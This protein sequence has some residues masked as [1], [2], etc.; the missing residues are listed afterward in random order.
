M[1]C[2]EVRLEKTVKERDDSQIFKN[3]P[4]EIIPKMTTAPIDGVFGVNPVTLEMAEDKDCKI[5]VP[6]ILI[7]LKK[8]IIDNNGFMLEGLFRIEGD[9]EK[10]RNLQ[11]DFNYKRP[12]YLGDSVHEATSLIKRWFDAL[13]DRLFGSLSDNTLE[14]CTKDAAG[15]MSIPERL[16]KLEADLFNWLIATLANVALNKEYTKM[17]PTN[18]GIVFGPLLAASVNPI[19]ALMQ[20]PKV[21]NIIA[22]HTKYRLAKQDPTRPEYEKPVTEEIKNIPLNVTNTTSRISSYNSRIKAFSPREDRRANLMKQ[23]GTLQAD[24]KSWSA[25]KEAEKIEQEK[26]EQEKQEQE[27]QEQEKQKKIAKD[28]EEQERLI[29][30]KWADEEGPIS[31]DILMELNALEQ[32]MRA[33]QNGQ[34]KHNKI[35]PPEKPQPGTRL[36]RTKTNDLEIPLHLQQQ[37]GA[38]DIDTLLENICLSNSKPTNLNPLTK[39]RSTLK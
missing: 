39:S 3:I 4:V 32:L 34:T 13:P 6:C 20:T 30:D 9:F 24:L 36:P 7:T 33:G 10:L 25:E 17:D 5:V 15:I 35:V 18:L 28:K 1:E 22:T 11:D 29:N 14:S 12:V 31:N 38:Y 16:P 21:V 37:A 19:H 8:C 23:M 26:Q 2:L 27:K